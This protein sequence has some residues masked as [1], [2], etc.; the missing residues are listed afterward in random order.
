VDMNQEQLGKLDVWA[1]EVE[2]GVEALSDGIPMD[3]PYVNDVRLYA[4]K[5][6]ALSLLAH[7]KVE[8]AEYE[9]RWSEI[10]TK[11]D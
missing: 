11:E 10:R 2:H 8:L 9:L 7:L 4:H 1:T 5:M 3:P 6:E